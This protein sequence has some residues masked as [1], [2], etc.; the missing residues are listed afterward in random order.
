[1]MRSTL[2][3]STLGVAASAL[4]AHSPVP[5]TRI[6]QNALSLRGGAA[7]ELSIASIGA[8]YSASLANRP[9]I[10]KSLTSGAIFALSDMTAQ[11]I[12]GDSDRSR[13]I[14]ST[15]V[16][17]LYFGPA[18]HY[19]LLMISKLIPGFSVVATL[20]KTL[21]G[22]SIFGPTITCVFFAAT[23]ISTSGLASGLAQLPNKIRQDLLVTWASGLGYWPFVDLIMYGLVPF[24]WIPLGYNIASFF[25][26]IYL[27]IQASRVVKS[28]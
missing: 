18:L 19:W 24:K 1:M 10:T 20:K 21:L 13:T 23:L 16:G 6:P 28:D 11:K 27:S 5:Y 17:L 15:L 3:L 25:W 22:Q 14:T 9:I 26:T 4:M 7:P 12:T 2:L 8:A